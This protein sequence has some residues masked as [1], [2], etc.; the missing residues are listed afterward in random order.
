MKKILFALAGALTLALTACMEDTGSRY[1]STFSRIVTIDN[2]GSSV[3]FI[4]DYTGEVFKNIENLKYT[5]HLSQFG[6]SNASRAEVYIQQDIDASY[7]QT[8]TLLQAEKINI[9]AVT[10]KEITD[11]TLP[12]LAWL[13]KP[14]GDIYNPT[15]WVS[16]YYLNVVPIIPSSRSGKYYLTADHVAGD[17][18]FFNLTASYNED[19][20]KQMIDYLQCYDLRTL[21]DTANADPKQRAKMEEVLAGIEL[22]Q[23]DSMRIVLIGDFIEYNFNYQGKDTIRTAGHITNYFRCNFIE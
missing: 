18:L 8:L 4:A 10:N 16:G 20:S 1:T 19:S 13:Q 6:L 3:R 12:L 2:A 15:V 17:T 21:C 11:K 23:R 5:E 7:N 9:Q 22:H 14:L